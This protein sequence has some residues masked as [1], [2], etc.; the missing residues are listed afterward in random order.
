MGSAIVSGTM[1]LMT[2]Q[3]WSRSVPCYGETDQT[4]TI[5]HRTRNQRGEVAAISTTDH[6]RMR[7]CSDAHL[8]RQSRDN[9]QVPHTDHS[10]GQDSASIVRLVTRR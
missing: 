10:I 9:D 1:Q 5:H 7:F 8:K 3:N 6:V 4:A 2:D